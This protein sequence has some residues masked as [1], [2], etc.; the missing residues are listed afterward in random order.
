MN[1]RSELAELLKLRAGEVA[2]YLYPAGKQEGREWVIGSIYGEAGKSLKICTE[3]DKVGV[4]CD[5]AGGKAGDLVSLW[6]EC[7]GGQFGETAA[8]IRGYLGLENP[9]SILPSRKKQYR[10]PTYQEGAKGV[11]K[12]GNSKV[13]LYL[14]KERGLT[15]ETI[16]AFNIGEM[17]EI[18]TRSGKKWKNDWI[19]IP[20]SHAGNIAGIKYQSIHLDKDG[21][22][23]VIPEHDCRPTL[24]GWRTIKS[25]DTVVCI[26]EGEIDAMTMFQY[27]HAAL[28]VPF[29][30]G[31][32][33]KQQW[34]E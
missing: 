15:S 34:I 9:K 5:F 10:S 28:S 2:R 11:D 27:G 22:K 3:G 24:F 7:K 4:W 26:T 21:K 33:D 32:G 23:V 25:T 13:S 18:T 20:Y 29:G 31:A 12:D 8:E 6:H 17:V 1:D 14:K 30:G 19:I 16:K